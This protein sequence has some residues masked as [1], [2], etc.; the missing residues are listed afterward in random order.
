MGDH[1]RFRAHGFVPAG[2]D[3]TPP[4]EYARPL[5]DWLRDRLIEQDMEVGELVVE[6]W[7]CLFGINRL[8]V[9]I[10]PVTGSGGEFL[11]FVEQIGPNFLERLLRRAMPPGPSDMATV[12]QR[13]DLALHA[14]PAITGIGWF[15]TNRRTGQESGHGDHP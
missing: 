2:G 11:A 15:E 6:D 1:V 10:G 4:G 3:E 7:G 8:A 14:N 9:C 13:I 5:T 12:I